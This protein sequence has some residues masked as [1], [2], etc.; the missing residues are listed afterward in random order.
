[1][2]N[3]FNARNA[4][5]LMWSTAL[6]AITM[7]SLAWAQAPAAQP[8]ATQATSSDNVEEIIVTAQRRSERLENVP[9][10]VA[11]ATSETLESTN[12]NSLRDINRLTSG[13]MLNQGGAF[14][15]ATIRGVTSL[16]NGTSFENNVAI[17]ID[18]IYQTATQG[19]NIDLP[20]V[21]D[22]QVLKGP[23]GTLYGRNATGGAILI[24]TVTPGKEWQGKAEATYAKFNDWRIGGY[25][26]GPITDWAGISIAGY[27][28]RTD[29]YFKLASRTVPGATHGNGAPL[30]QD[31]IRL[32]LKLN[33]SNDFSAIFGY[34]YTHISD[35][36]GNMFSD[37]ENVS[38]LLNSATRPTRLGVVAF[39]H[40]D[41]IETWSHEGTMTLSWDTGI[42]AL[43]SYPS[44]TSFKP[45]TSFDFDGTYRELSAWSTS[46][47]RQKTFQESVDYAINAIPHFDLV[48]GGNYFKDR[49]KTIGPHIAN[50]SGLIVDQVPG[51]GWVT[52]AP[53]SNLVQNEDRRFRQTKEAWAVYFDATWHVTDQLHLNVGGRYSK[54]SQ[55]VFGVSRCFITPV[56]LP[57]NVC[58]FLPVVDGNRFVFP[59]TNKSSSYKKFT[60]RASIRYEIAPRTNVYASYSQG[61]RSGAW[62]ASLPLIQRVGGVLVSGPPDW[63]DAQQEVVDAFE[64]GFKTARRNFRFETSAFL[65]KYKD[66]QVSV[67]QCIGAPTCVTQTVVTNA[68]KANIKGL[69]ASAEYKPIE[70][71]N[72]R[73]NFTW[74]HAR[75]GKGFQFNFTGVDCTPNPPPNNPAGGIGIN[76]NS[77]L[78]KTCL[79]VTQLQNL[80]GL[81]MARSPNFSANL[82]FTY[83]IP[84]GEGGFRFAGNMYYTSKYVVT[85]PSV[86]CTPTAGVAT[87]DCGLVPADRQREQ[88]FV[89]G[90]Y[91]LLSGSVQYTLPNGH[92]Y[93][94]VWGNNLNNKKYRLHYTGTSFGSY[95]PLAE[96]RTYGVTAG[97]KF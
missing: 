29:G 43:K 27:T 75:Y 96:P 47:F 32:K 24:N 89:Q 65:Y 88:R 22:V 81:P 7:P 8:S 74:L 45:I 44:Y 56:T 16:A 40:G 50:Y 76:T 18:G 90:S 14:P 20:N 2:M 72:L 69:E 82:G 61:F 1:M 33:L 36:R 21:S 60:P 54:E 46:V 73:G 5:V 10:T 94:R 79:N 77:D 42:G 35:A 63:Q 95:S 12:A 38:P 71:L 66:L 57:S 34:N 87:A 41:R 64:I 39:D 58:N 92:V 26:A 3:Q 68:P 67:T 83:D 4:R 49:L 51:F 80:S 30:E 59:A 97:F 48:V 93:V 91:V 55:D 11:V 6:T 19:T 84:M 86:W 13:V 70:N 37:F 28:R 53:L 78:L 17:Y 52:P 25:F 31:A 62:N 85:N 23:Q 9:M 15:A